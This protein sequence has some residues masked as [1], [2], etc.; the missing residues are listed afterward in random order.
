[1]NTVEP[2]R[3]KKKIREILVDL[4]YETSEHGKRMYLLFA[5]LLYTGLRISDA[6]ELRR[7]HV[8]KAD[9]LILEEQKTGK[10]VTVMI[11]VELRRI[12]DNRL[13]DL[14]PDD[15]IFP[16]R[17]SRKDGTNRHITTRT[18]GYDLKAIQKR[19][20][21][22]APF[23]CHSM[24]KTYGYFR[25]KEGASLETLRQHFNH[26]DEATTRRYIG[27]DEEER[28]KDL[29]RFSF[30]YTPEEQKRKP[31]NRGRKGAALEIKTQDRKKQGEAWGR[32]KR[33]ALEKKAKKKQYDHERYLKRKAA[34][35][36]GNCL[37]E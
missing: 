13:Y 31:Y 3:D 2:I 29:Q 20:D 15:F 11:P 26:A 19:F 12:Y 6:V 32:S 5:T 21:I 7:K 4:E 36:G 8:Y 16:S 30:R 9:F 37:S 25:Y 18:A 23:A 10:R 27:I 14:Q 34:Q 33:A 22:K 28:N 17:Q 24:R 1:M 35:S